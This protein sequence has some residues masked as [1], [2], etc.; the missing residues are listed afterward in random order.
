MASISNIKMNYDPEN[1]EIVIFK[2]LVY[3]F[4]VLIPQKTGIILSTN[5]KMS[6]IDI[7]IVIYEFILSSQLAQI[8]IEKIKKWFKGEHMCCISGLTSTSSKRNIIDNKLNTTTKKI[9]FQM[10]CNRQKINNELNKSINNNSN[11]L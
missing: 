5:D 3:I 6:M 8:Y 11:D 9:E 4:L 7:L 10:H 1:T 2:I